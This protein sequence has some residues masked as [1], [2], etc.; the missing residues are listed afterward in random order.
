MILS[1]LLTGKNEERHYRINNTAKPVSLPNEIHP[2]IPANSN[3]KKNKNPV[4]P[5]IKKPAFTAGFISPGGKTGTGPDSHDIHFR[6]V[7]LG[8][9]Q[10]SLASESRVMTVVT[11]MPKHQT[12]RGIQK[13]DMNCPV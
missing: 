5:N 8:Q 3:S 10:N 2:G 1:L 9:N 7:P 12:A 11:S 13:D 6:S 4:S